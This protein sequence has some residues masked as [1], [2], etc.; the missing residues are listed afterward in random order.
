LYCPKKVWQSSVE[1]VMKANWE[2]DN[3]W[4]AERAEWVYVP[5]RPKVVPIRQGR[6]RRVRGVLLAFAASIAIWVVLGQV[7]LMLVRWI[8]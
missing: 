2:N 5:V 7:T 8:P 4:M 3:E 1:A 6:K